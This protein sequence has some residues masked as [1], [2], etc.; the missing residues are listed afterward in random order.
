MGTLSPVGVGGADESRM[1]ASCLGLR[2]GEL[3][4]P[5]RSRYPPVS[6]S[7]A[8]VLRDGECRDGESR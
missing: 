8:R 4:A 3:G 6:T 1:Y 7:W 5:I 2:V